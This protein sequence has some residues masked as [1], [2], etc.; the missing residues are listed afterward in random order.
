MLIFN[1]HAYLSSSTLLHKTIDISEIQQS[2]G[3]KFVQIL[4]SIWTIYVISDHIRF[5]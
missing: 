1:L 5:D 2:K 3:L 4:T